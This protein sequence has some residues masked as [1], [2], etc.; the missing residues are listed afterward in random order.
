M[1]KIIALV[2]A[3]LMM[4]SIFVACGG[5]NTTDNS[6]GD[7]SGSNTADVDPF[8][9]EDNIT[10]KVWAPE[11]AKATFEKQCQDFIAKYPDKTISIEVVAQADS[12]SASALLNDPDAAADV[13]GFPVDQLNRMYNAGVL[14]PVFD[15]YVDDV[16]ARNSEF[17]INAATMG[18]ALQAFPETGQ[19][20]YCLF[21]DKSIVSDEDAKTLEGVL[22]ACRKGGRKFIMDA[23]N[24]FYSCTF[25]YTGGLINTGLSEDGVQEFSDY[26]EAKVVDTLAAFSALFHE[27]SDVFESN[28]NGKIASGMAENPPK[29][30]AGITGDWDAASI[31]GILGENYGAVKLPTINVGGTDVQMV[32]MNG[33]KLMGVNMSS[34]YLDAAQCLADFLTSEECQK[35]RLEENSW[36]PSNTAVAESDAVKANIALSALLDQAQYSVPQVNIADTFWTPMG[37]LGEAVYKKD[38][39]TDKDYL[40]EQLNKCIANIKDE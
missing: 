15:N 21:Y 4:A 34:K 16:T 25:V 32:S 7:N 36:A 10:L 38:N 37:T 30:A 8:G 9:G 33:C 14:A 24:G 2:L 5:G 6:G 12:D 26:D 3:V 17:T 40:T 28:S 39:P 29:V 1:K 19:N 22:E 20:G 23:G 13:L 11:A 18:G 27:Y 31:E 35:E